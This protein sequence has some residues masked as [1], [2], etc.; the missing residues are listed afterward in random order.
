[1]NGWELARQL[2]HDG[3]VSSPIIMISANA[4]EL[5]QALRLDPRSFQANTQLLVLYRRTHD[6]Q[7]DQQAQR[8]KEL[9]EDRSRRADLMLR[10]IELRP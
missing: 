10:T 1:M 3:F 4:G 9:D 6:P 2:R 7:A 5:S 8:G